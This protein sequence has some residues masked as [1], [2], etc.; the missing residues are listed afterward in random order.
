MQGSL[1]QH[2][3]SVAASTIL[4]AALGSFCNQDARTDRL[5]WLQRLWLVVVSVW[6]KWMSHHSAAQVP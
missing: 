1:K 4:S 2:D 6:I 5:E 3:Y